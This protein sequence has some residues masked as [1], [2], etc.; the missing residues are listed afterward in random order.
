MPMEEA[1]EKAVWERVRGKKE[2]PVCLCARCAGMT[3]FLWKQ[4]VSRETT[5]KLMQQ[6]MHQLDTLRG[7][8]ALTGVREPDWVMAEPQGVAPRQAAAQCVA[9][10]RELATEYARWEQDPAFSGLFRQLEEE[11]WAMVGEMA[12]LFLRL[13]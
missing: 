2:L 5:R 3:R 13:G 9:L 11:A 1:R 10:L 4:G 6:L 7:L 8:T 12:R